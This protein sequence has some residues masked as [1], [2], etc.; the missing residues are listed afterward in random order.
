MRCTVVLEFDGGDTT[1]VKR[2]ELVRLHRDTAKPVSGDVGLSLAEGKTLIQSVQQEFTAEQLGQ[3]CEGRRECQACGAVRRLHDS[4]CAS[5]R[6]TLGKVYHCH[7]RWKACVCGAD[8]TRYVSPLKAYVPDS[9]T[10]ELRWL[11]ATLGAMMPYRQAM[12]VMHLLL[13]T[14]GRDNHVTLRNHTLSVG[15]AIQ[16]AEPPGPHWPVESEAELG[17]DVGYVRKVKRVSKGDEV[18]KDSSSIAIV[19]AAVGPVGKPPR[20]WASALPRSKR[21]HIE[22]AKFLKNSGYTADKRVRVLSDGAKDL[23]DVAAALPHDSRWVLDWAH[24]GR[25]LRHVE[26]AIAPLAYGRLT[27]AGSAF[28]LWDLFVRFRSLVWTGQTQRWQRAGE[29]LFQLLELRE[30]RDATGL[31]E[32]ARSALYKLLDVLFYLRANLSS[33]VDYR[34]WQQVG[35]RISTGYVESSINRIVGRRMCKGQQMRWSRAGAHGLVQVRAALLNRE[36]D[37]LAERNSPWIG[38]HRVSWS[39]PRPPHPF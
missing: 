1:P 35:R 17:I 22:M 2:V 23:A 7:E 21:L 15:A 25:M 11:H 19:V 31:G 20:V 32:R 16:E 8:G 13:P 36:L 6:T 5:L 26:Q 39:W 10:G 4:H 27:P 30:Q 24:I 28:E 33:L 38:K 9:S 29:R 14:S 12:A 18:I 37:D 34:S 3:F